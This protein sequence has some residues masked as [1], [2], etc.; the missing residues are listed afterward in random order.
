MLYSVRSYEPADQ[1]YVYSGVYRSFDDGMRFKWDIM[2]SVVQ[3]PD[4]LAR[5][6]I[7]GA[8]YD[9]VLEEYSERNLADNDD[10]GELQF[11]MFDD[12]VKDY[13]A[14]KRPGWELLLDY[15]Y[16]RDNY[17]VEKGE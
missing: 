15:D 7:L 6:L 4:E 16:E 17:F 5:K 3:I 8:I 1:S 2:D 14:R 12:E 11:D 10:Y 13:I 9:Q